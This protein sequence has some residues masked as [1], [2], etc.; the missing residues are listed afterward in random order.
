MF[1]LDLYDCNVF[2]LFIF[3]K[4]NVFTINF[5][6]CNEKVFSALHCYEKWVYIVISSVSMFHSVVCIYKRGCMCV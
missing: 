5:W 6:W 3:C 4:D 2:F 1:Y